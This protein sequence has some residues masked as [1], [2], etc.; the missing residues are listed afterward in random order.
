MLIGIVS[1]ALVSDTSVIQL[2][3][4]LTE[5]ADILIPVPLSGLTTVRL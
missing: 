5:I 4:K 3:A 1:V 2:G